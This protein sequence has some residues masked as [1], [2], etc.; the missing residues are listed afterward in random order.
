MSLQN[1]RRPGCYKT[2][3]RITRVTTRTA[4]KPLAI[5]QG[6]R[7]GIAFM[8]T[9]ATKKHTVL[10][11]I[12]KQWS[13][14]PG[15]N[16]MHLQCPFRLIAT[17]I[18]TLTAFSRPHLTQKFFVPC[19]LPI[20]WACASTPVRI[21]FT[22]HFP[23]TCFAE[24]RTRCLRHWLAFTWPWLSFQSATDFL[25][26]CFGRYPTKGRWFSLTGR[27]NLGACF[28]RLC[29]IICQVAMAHTASLRTINCSTPLPPLSFIGIIAHQTYSLLNT[30]NPSIDKR[31]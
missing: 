3:V 20:S 1:C 21:V 26:C 18:L 7:L 10:R 24:L 22:E 2:P 5:F 29:R 25:A 8:V 16:M 14:N 23:S 4:R 13:F 6:H 12:T 28:S 19:R 11:I 17:T 15:K 31:L 30:H 27:A 9:R